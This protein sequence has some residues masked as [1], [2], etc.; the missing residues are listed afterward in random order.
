MPGSKIVCAGDKPD[1]LPHQLFSAATTPPSRSAKISAVVFEKTELFPILPK[2]PPPKSKV[3]L[4]V[5]SSSI[6]IPTFPLDTTVVFCVE[7]LTE[8][9]F[10]AEIN[11][12]DEALLLIILLSS[13]GASD[14]TTIISADNKT[15]L[16]IAIN[17]AVE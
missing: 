12:P 1:A 5:V 8:L 9:K 13:S 10:A 16:R 7:A 11:I 3:K 17:C 2:I 4:F 15:L 14:F 6:N